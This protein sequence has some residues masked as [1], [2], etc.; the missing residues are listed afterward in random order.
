M[1]VLFNEQPLVNLAVRGNSLRRIFTIPEHAVQFGENR[2]RLHF[3][4]EGD[5]EVPTASLERMEVGTLEQIR[6]GASAGVVL[7]T[8][9]SSGWRGDR[10]LGE[11]AGWPSISCGRAP[12]AAGVV[13]RG[14]G[15]LGMRASGDRRRGSAPRVLLAVGAARL[16]GQ[17]SEIDVA[18][19]S[20]VPTSALDP[21]V[22]GH[23]GVPRTRGR[24]RCAASCTRPLGARRPSPPSAA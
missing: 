15:S 9:Y 1:T 19:Y 22:S 20:G 21:Q 23:V 8:L 16:G 6:A 12:R 17:V 24:A 3:R 7:E 4:K 18:G 13:G 2:V 14:V 5:A 10:F 11:T